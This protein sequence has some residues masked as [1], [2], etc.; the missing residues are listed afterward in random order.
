[1]FWL[2]FT[3]KPKFN[4]LSRVIC[5][6]LAAGG[7]A[8][9]GSISSEAREKTHDLS[10]P[11][12]KYN[13]NLDRA[14]LKNEKRDFVHSFT[15]KPRYSSI[16]K[17][18]RRDV[19]VSEVAYIAIAALSM[20]LPSE[21]VPAIAKIDQRF[22]KGN[23]VSVAGYSIDK[24]GLT[25]HRNCRTKTRMM[26]GKKHPIVRT[27]CDVV[28]GDSGSPL[29][30]GE[31][32]NENYSRLIVAGSASSIRSNT[33]LVTFNTLT[34]HH[35]KNTPFLI[36]NEWGDQI[37]PSGTSCKIVTSSSLN[38]RPTPSTQHKKT[39]KLGRGDIV[40]ELYSIN[41]WNLIKF[42]DDQVGY[43]SAKYLSSVPCP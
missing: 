37:K 26:N 17:D 34:S 3:L 18:D 8:C 33:L 31:I 38:V 10:Y 40:S 5:H 21:I 28:S 41:G 7:I 1:M 20:P 36:P 27:D 39:S 2:M 13:Q 32:N 22:A 6:S 15:G 30:V 19:Y 12:Q 43:S 23:H 25:E 29:I 16:I 42:G 4:N 24:R 14:H 11:T 9:G 35:I